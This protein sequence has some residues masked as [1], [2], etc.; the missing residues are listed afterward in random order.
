MYV[1]SR[2]RAKGDLPTPA[3]S[4]QEIQMPTLLPTVASSVSSQALHDQVIS[5][6]PGTSGGP[7]AYKEGAFGAFEKLNFRAQL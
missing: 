5:L 4:K 1:C 3:H 2:L 6:P 7:C